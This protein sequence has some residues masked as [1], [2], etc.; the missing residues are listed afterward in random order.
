MKTYLETLQDWKHE[1]SNLANGNTFLEPTTDEFS[2]AS[3]CAIVQDRIELLE[4]A[5]K[6]VSAIIKLKS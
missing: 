4:Q 3:K 6:D 5:I 2:F 1:F